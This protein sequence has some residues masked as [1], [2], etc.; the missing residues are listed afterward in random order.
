M[1]TLGGTRKKRRHANQI[2]YG[3]VNTLKT[4]FQRKNTT[5]V[6]KPIPVPIV[7]RA[8]TIPQAPDVNTASEGDIHAHI[9]LLA[10]GLVYILKCSSM[11]VSEVCK[12]GDNAACHQIIDFR[13]TKPAMDYLG[14]CRNNLRAPPECVNATAYVRE[15]DSFRGKLK[16]A[17]IN[18]SELESA[19]KLV[20]KLFNEFTENYRERLEQIKPVVSGENS[21]KPA[22]IS[23]SSSSQKT[24][25][26]TRMQAPAKNE[27]SSWCPTRNANNKCVSNLRKSSTYIPEKESTVTQFTVPQPPP[28]Q[29]KA[30]QNMS[31]QYSPK[32]VFTTNSIRRGGKRTKQSTKARK[33][34]K[35]KKVT[36]SRKAKNQR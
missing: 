17:S 26:L 19:Y 22:V 10:D 13:D 25:K 31:P 8:D 1:G 2:G 23:P 3:F 11:C 15:L 6:Q 4:F 29:F 20:D 28:Q 36:R 16:A 9:N 5:A 34:R 12:K 24:Q 32:V 21:D 7:R 27:V 33:T 14:F 30:A 18:R 35:T